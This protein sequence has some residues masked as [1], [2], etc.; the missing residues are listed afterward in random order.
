MTFANCCEL[1]DVKV[2][3]CLSFSE[4]VI[5]KRFEHQKSLFRSNNALP[6]V[7]AKFN[8]KFALISIIFAGYV[9]E[10]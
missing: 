9:Y 1:Q 3:K 4:K 8:V 7:Y 6:N 10:Q 5:V 2:K